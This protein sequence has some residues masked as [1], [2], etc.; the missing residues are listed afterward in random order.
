MDPGTDSPEAIEN[1]QRAANETSMIFELKD[2]RAFQW[3]EREFIQTAYA[4]AFAK[5]R[6]PNLRLPEESLQNIQMTYVALRKV[7]VGML[8]REIIHRELLDPNDSA[9]PRLRE[10][11][12]AL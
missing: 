12:A 10:K 6:D 1:R 11:L 7:R 4:E 2:N 8:E 3:F 9:L 5:L